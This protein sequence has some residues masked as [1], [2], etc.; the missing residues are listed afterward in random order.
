MILAVIGEEPDCETVCDAYQ[1]TSE[2]KARLTM[3]TVNLTEVYATIHKR[4][5]REKANEILEIIR[6]DAL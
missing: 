4:E 3:H 6:T 2:G 5:G 1:E